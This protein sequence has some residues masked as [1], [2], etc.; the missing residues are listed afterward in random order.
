MPPFSIPASGLSPARYRAKRSWRRR[1]G[2][3]RAYVRSGL[4]RTRNMGAGLVIVSNRLPFTL[5]LDHAELRAEPSA[6]GLVAALEGVRPESVWVGWPGLA[7][8]EE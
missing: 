8:P 6:G 4:G 2:P 5:S 1:E 7:V 3:R